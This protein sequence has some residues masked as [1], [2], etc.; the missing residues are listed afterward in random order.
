MKLSLKASQQGL[1][2]CPDPSGHLSTSLTASQLALMR[3]CLVSGQRC[4]GQSPTGPDS[5]PRLCC[6]PGTAHLAQPGQARA[7]QARL[8]GY[9]RACWAAL[10]CSVPALPGELRANQKSRLS[11]AQ[12]HVSVP[13]QAG[14]ASFSGR[15]LRRAPGHG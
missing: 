8:H 7:Q 13:A 14:T 12:S 5:W 15:L 4:Q 6:V 2:L 1:K 11:L 3:P 10:S 9:L